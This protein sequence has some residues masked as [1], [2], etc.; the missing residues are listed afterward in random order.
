MARGVFGELVILH[1]APISEI[2]AHFE[3]IAQWTTPKTKSDSGFESSRWRIYS[4]Q[5]ASFQ[6]HATALA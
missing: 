6:I 5:A 4:I 2:E 1:D 3:T